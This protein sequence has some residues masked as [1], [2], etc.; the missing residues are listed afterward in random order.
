V[1]PLKQK[2]FNMNLPTISFILTAL[3]ST[4]TTTLLL[5]NYFGK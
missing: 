2:I 3:T 5:I 1:E 4:V